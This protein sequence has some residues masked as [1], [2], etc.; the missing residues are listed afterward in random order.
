M[1]I[2]ATIGAMF[3]LLL[4][5]CDLEKEPERYSP[6]L[7]NF[8]TQHNF[9]SLRGNIKSFN[10]KL[11]KDDGELLSEV[12]GVLSKNG[13]VQS[14]KANILF[15]ELH[16]DFMIEGDYLVDVES[17]QK[18]A[19]VN[20]E[21]R[22]VDTEVSKYEY[23]KDGLISKVT[24]FDQGYE[25]IDF[26]QYDDDGLPAKIDSVNPKS[27]RMFSRSENKKKSFDQTLHSVS[28]DKTSDTVEKKCVYDDHY[29][30]VKCDIVVTEA[31]GEI[32]KFNMIYKTEYY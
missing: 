32:K 10:Q 6:I 13:C 2:K 7:T 27:T 3:S 30:P 17:K 11:V 24:T 9:D 15:F 12:S 18:I 21:C 16:E 5:G 20:K 28:E 4:V 23:N 22:L 25:Y 29:N 8:A 14:L 26:Y 19:N 31:N 1:K